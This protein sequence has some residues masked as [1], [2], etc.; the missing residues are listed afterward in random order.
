MSYWVYRNQYPST[1]AWRETYVCKLS[2]DE[3]RC[4]PELIWK[5]YYI[6]S[7]ASKIS[8][9]AK[10]FLTFPIFYKRFHY[11]VWWSYLCSTF[12]Y[13]FFVWWMNHGRN[14][15][16]NVNSM[17]MR[18]E[19]AGN[20]WR[21]SLYLLTNYTASGYVH[22]Y[23]YILSAHVTSIKQIGAKDPCRFQIKVQNF[24]K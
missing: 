12:V 19:N 16:V 15:S 6:C 9:L 2:R 23:F 22:V 14:T 18:K 7:Q 21:L 5:A 20:V 4:E 8:N 10:I 1:S 17:S 24:L 13:P 3:S 11:A